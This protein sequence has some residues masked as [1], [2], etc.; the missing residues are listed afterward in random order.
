[1]SLSSLRRSVF[2]GLVTMPPKARKTSLKKNVI[3][4]R[5]DA[6]PR[7]EIWGMHLANAPREQIITL[8]ENRD[9]SGSTLSAVDILYLLMN[10]ATR[11]FSD[12]DIRR[13]K[14]NNPVCLVDPSITILGEVFQHLTTKS[15]KTITNS[16]GL[17]TSY[18]K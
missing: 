1:M 15:C 13:A 6:F 17:S 5:L 16:I 2:V 10:I 18:N 3:I 12:V 14:K 9:G 4:V 11:R 8:V 7:G